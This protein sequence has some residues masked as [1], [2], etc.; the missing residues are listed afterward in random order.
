MSGP[1]EVQAAVFGVFAAIAVIGVAL[2][3]LSRLGLLDHD[4]WVHGD[5]PLP[6]PQRE[7]R[8]VPASTYKVPALHELVARANTLPA[9]CL[10]VHVPVSPDPRRKEN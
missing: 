1:E 8:R 7:P 3:V 6:T 4:G 10:P 5:K 2:L 9:L